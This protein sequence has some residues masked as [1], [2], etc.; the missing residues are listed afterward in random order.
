M[1]EKNGFRKRAG[2]AALAWAAGLLAARGA[3]LTD[4]M[5]DTWVATDGE[6]RSLPTSAEAGLP[7]KDRTVALFYFL[8]HKRAPDRTGPY[9]MAKILAQDPKALENDPSLPVE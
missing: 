5:S 1:S 2:L 8:T 9:D 4:V 3:D 7:R 6:G